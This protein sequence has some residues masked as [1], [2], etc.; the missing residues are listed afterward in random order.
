MGKPDFQVKWGN[1]MK[2]ASV[3]AAAL[4]VDMTADALPAMSMAGSGEAANPVLRRPVDLVHL[5]RYTLGN[6]AL[7]REV[8]E[9][10]RTQS[11]I[12]LARLKEAGTEKAWAEAAHTIKGSARGIGAWRVAST[13]ESAEGLKGKSFKSS[14]QGIVRALEAAIGETN[15]FI[16]AL[17]IDA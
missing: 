9:L 3:G 6:R 16:E 10:F 13:A 17:L 14:R 15:A 1:T 4:A 11:E 8:L 7:E 5:A 12:Y 2:S